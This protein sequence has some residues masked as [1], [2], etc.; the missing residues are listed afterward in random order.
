MNKPLISII[1]TYYKKKKYIKKTIGSIIGQSYK[2]FQ[3][4]FVYDDIDKKDLNYI[5]K[6]IKKIK[7]KK[8][9]INK[10][11]FGVAMSRNIASKYI[12][13][14]F[15]AFIDADDIWKKNKLK[16]QLIFMLKSNSDISYTSY[17]IID[18]T[19]KFQGK[20][21][22]PKNISYESLSKKCDIGLSSVLLK[23]KILQQNKFPRLKTQEDFGLWLKLIRKGY[24][25]QPI[26]RTYMK[27]RKDRNSLSSNTI[28]KI[29]DALKLFY[30]YENKNLILSI[31]SVITLSINKILN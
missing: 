23:S 25:F 6:I 31:Y 26:E 5:Q 4:I 9:I 19:G 8:L 12:K 2:N 20:R 3:L 22:V 21:I 16:D 17:E 7:N 18:T 28:Q 14:K 30:K 24:K 27:W 11:N 1:L 29:F 10:K 13:G 15:T